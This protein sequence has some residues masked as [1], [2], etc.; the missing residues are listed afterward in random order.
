MLYTAKV[1]IIYRRLRK[2]ENGSLIVLLTSLDD[3]VM[4]NGGYA[5]IQRSELLS[6]IILF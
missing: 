5:A 6:Y 3:L 4:I 1:T 2:N